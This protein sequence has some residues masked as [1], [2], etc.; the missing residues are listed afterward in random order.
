MSR[1][2]FRKTSPWLARAKTIGL[3]V[4]LI[5]P[6]CARLGIAAD[7][8]VKIGFLLKTMQE[9]RYQTDKAEFIKHAESLGAKVLFDSSGNNEQ[10][11]LGQFEKMLDDG[12]QVIVLQPV[13]TGLATTLVRLANQKGVKVIGYDAMP[14]NGPLD[15]MVM[16]DSWK[17]GQL[18]AEAMLKW[19]QQKRGKLEGTVALIMGQPGDSNAQALSQGVIDTIEKTPGLKLAAQIAHVD[20]S[21]D[22]SAE[23][24]SNL[25]VRYK[26]KVDAFICN[27]SGL[28]SGVIAALDLEQLADAGQVFVA[29]ADA[30]LKNIRYVAQGKQAVDVWKPIKPLAQKAAAIAVEIVRNPTKPLAAIAQSAS[31]EGARFTLIDNGF[32]KVPTVIT[33]VVLITQDNI[34]S[35]LIAEKIFSKEQV[36]GE[37]K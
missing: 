4:L 29:G 16:Q 37:K 10:R 5:V 11:Q 27:N 34:D 31:Q 13:N 12:A 36:Y 18:Q 25:L 8:S 23:T 14:V 32:A 3:M 28:A 7:S 26:N 22:R 2:S 21:P 30:D 1:L 35:T 9:E 33:P 6:L 20:W 19:L 17:V 24:A 15:M